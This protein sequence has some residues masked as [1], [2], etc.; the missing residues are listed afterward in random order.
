MLPYHSRTPDIVK[1]VRQRWL[2]SYWLRLRGGRPLPLW[3]DLDMAELESCFDDLTILDV[4][5]GKGT[6]RFRIFDHGK[7]VGA[8]YAG[9]CAGKYLEET[10]PD[11]ARAHTLET[12]EHAARNS[13]PVYT[14][15]K[16]AD[17]D[18]RTVLVER[19]L[20]PFSEFGGP[21]FRIIGFLEAIS[22]EG[23]FGRHKL[24][25][26]RRDGEGFAFKAVLEERAGT[27]AM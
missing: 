27:T 7:N 2:Y 6:M 17:A 1:S 11:A 19:L 13:L 10:L 8:M 20:L 5:S 25:I 23:E 12:Y 26:E 15:S 21:V 9:Q 16:V 22:P 4:L 24:M 18:R 3:S 14:V